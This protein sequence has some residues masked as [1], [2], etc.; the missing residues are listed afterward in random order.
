MIFRGNQR[1][2]NLM[3]VTPRVGM[4]GNGFFRLSETIK[5]LNP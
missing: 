2:C 5:I 4:R 3:A 1:I